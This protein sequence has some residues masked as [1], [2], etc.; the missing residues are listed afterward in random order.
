MRGRVRSAPGTSTRTSFPLFL[1]LLLLIV[2]QEARCRVVRSTQRG[3]R[4]AHLHRGATASS[5]VIPPRNQQGS[6]L[7]D[8]KRSPTWSRLGF[9]GSAATSPRHQHQQQKQHRQ[10]LP[11]ASRAHGRG[12]PS[13]HKSRARC[14]RQCFPPSRPDADV[15]ILSFSMTDS[16]SQ[17]SALRPNGDAARGALVGYGSA[18]SST[19]AQRDPAGLDAPSEEVAGKLGPCRCGRG[20]LGRAPLESHLSPS[21]FFSV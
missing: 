20:G 13:Q 14:S 8:T 19:Q 12:T 21:R 18:S 11:L 9:C 17:R 2:A 7:A 6:L 3:A 16:P 5:R 15:D 1:L 10:Q 4:A